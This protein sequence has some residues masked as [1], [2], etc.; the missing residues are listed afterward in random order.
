MTSLIDIQ[1][2]KKEYGN[3]PNGS[4]ATQVADIY[5]AFA[6]ERI[7]GHFYRRATYEP[8]QPVSDV[9]M[10]TLLHQTTA[11]RERAAYIHVPFC[12]RICTFCNFRRRLHHEDQ[13]AQYVAGIEQELSMYSKMPYTQAK[14]FCSVYFGGGTPTDISAAQMETILASIHRNLPISAAAE[15]ASEARIDGFDREKMEVMRRYG[16]ERISFGVQTFS[17]QLRQQLGRISTREE[18]IA[19]LKEARAI[20][21]WVAVDL[22]SNLPGQTFA[23][24]QRDI[25]ICLE[26]E[27]DGIEIYSLILMD[28]T[29]LAAGIA[30]G[31]IPAVDDLR[32]EIDMYL[33]GMERL[34]AYGYFQV[35]L[36]HFSKPYTERKL[37]IKTRRS[38]GDTFGFGPGAGGNFGALSYSNLLDVDEYYAALQAGKFPVAMRITLSRKDRFVRYVTENLTDGSSSLSMKEAE[39]IFGFSVAAE[40]GAVIDDMKAR[41]LVEING[42]ELRLT[43]IGCVWGY[44][45][46]KSFYPQVSTPGHPHAVK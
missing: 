33:L 26:L 25:D 13:A 32:K 27:L 3:M 19:R 15:I 37:Y 24:W 41:G 43:R 9:E 39:E 4:T 28:G 44:N 11:E 7:K 12:R 23:D 40:F 38:G 18:I 34:L 22:I 8:P 6:E 2:I 46:A 30:A 35:G 31:K 10:T 20:G 1:W 45:V 16:V 17:T 21:F 5:T 42:D 29:P 36:F 14:E